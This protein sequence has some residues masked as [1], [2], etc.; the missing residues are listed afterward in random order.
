MEYETTK[1]SYCCKKE[2]L[3]GYSQEDIYTCPGCKRSCEAV[4]VCANCLGTKNVPEDEEDGEGHTMRGVGMVQCQACRK[5]IE[6]DDM[7]DDS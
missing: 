1:V 7:D 4:E 3:K 2:F 6:E 5:A